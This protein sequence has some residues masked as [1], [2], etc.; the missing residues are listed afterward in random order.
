MTYIAMRL[1]AGSGYSG[2]RTIFKASMAKFL[3]DRSSVS[4][5]ILGLRKCG[6]RLNAFFVVSK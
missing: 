4:S 2:G 5:L 6:R 3:L 1:S